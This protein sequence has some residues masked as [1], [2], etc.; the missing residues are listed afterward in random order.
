MPPVSKLRAMA[1]ARSPACRP[2]ARPSRR[3]AVR[4]PLPSVVTAR[5]TALPTVPATSRPKAWPR[6]D[7][8]APPSMVTGERAPWIAP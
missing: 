1:A 5:S 3:A 6:T 2:K 8:A 7:A 4:A